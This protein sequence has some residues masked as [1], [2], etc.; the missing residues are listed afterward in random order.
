VDVLKNNNALPFDVVFNDFKNWV[1]A[2]YS[3]AEDIYFIGHNVFTFD[4]RFIEV[5]CQRYSLEIPQNWIFVDS[6]LQFRKYNSD[7]GCDNFKLITLYNYLKDDSIE[8]EGNLHN[9]LT[10]CKILQYVYYKLIE[11]FSLKKK[12]NLLNEGK[13]SI[14][15]NSEYLSKNINNIIDLTLIQIKKFN[16]NNIRTIQDLL[17]KYTELTANS[18]P[19]NKKFYKF[20]ELI[21]LSF[22]ERR[23]L[24]SNIQYISNIVII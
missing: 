22:E 9:S 14:T 18:N 8:I 4:M 24:T 13:R 23:K 6:L 21:H 3:D 1:N 7:L 17:C 20:L 2:Y 5:S 15:Y 10:D 11:D 19:I 16:E 12:K